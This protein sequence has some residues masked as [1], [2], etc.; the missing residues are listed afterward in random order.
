MRLLVENGADA[1]AISKYFHT[2]LSAPFLNKEN[3]LNEERFS[4]LVRSDLNG[5]KSLFY[6]LSP[7]SAT[8]SE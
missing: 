2:A 3:S 7:L 6:R 1:T 8:F 4:K 5:L